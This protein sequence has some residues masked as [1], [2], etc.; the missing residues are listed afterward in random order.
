MVIFSSARALLLKPYGLI[1]SLI[2]NS[3]RLYLGSLTLVALL[4]YAFV[5]LFPALVLA[6][7][8]NIYQAL[9]VNDAINKE[10]FVPQPQEIAATK[11]LQGPKLDQI[12]SQDNGNGPKEV[13][14]KNPS[15]QSPLLDGH[16]E[17]P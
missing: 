4:G 7:L 8:L 10:M 13:G 1:K 3:P 6:G 5:L 14:P 9:T 17:R 2:H 11:K 15:S 12:G 16:L